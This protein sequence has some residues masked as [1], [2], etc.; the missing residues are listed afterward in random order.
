MAIKVLGVHPVPEAPEPCALIEVEIDEADEFDWGAVMQEVEGQH[1][2]NRTLV[3]DD[4]ASDWEETLQEHIVS[5]I[6][7]DFAG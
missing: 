7:H 2:K 5:T 3:A 4:V 6:T 1:L